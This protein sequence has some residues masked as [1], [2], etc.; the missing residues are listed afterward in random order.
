LDVGTSAVKG[1]VLDREGRVLARARRSY[2]LDLPAPGRVE[3][4]AERV[5]SAVAGV[6]G[7][8]GAGATAGGSPVRALAVSGSGDEVVAVDAAG[9][10]AGPVI[11]A[12][13]TRSAATAQALE[14][15]FGEARLYARTGLAAIGMAPLT[16]LLW[17]REYQPATAARIRRLLAW[18]EYVALRLGVEPRAEPTLAG[19]SLV[20]DLHTDAYAAD[21][22]E[23][24]D[25]DQ[26]TFPAIVPT[27]ARIGEVSRIMAGR[28]GLSGN[29]AVV[30]GGFDQAMAAFGA[31]ALD[32][33]TAHVGT[34]SWEALSAPL[35]G[36][37]I[38]EGLRIGGWSI[39]RTV[40][41]SATHAAMTSWV[42]GAVLHWLARLSSVDRWPTGRAPSLPRLLREAPDGP[43]R[44]LALT[45]LAG[46]SS[47]YP[48]FAGG[49]FVGLD[50][51]ASRGE[52]VA[53]ALESLTFHLRA[54]LDQ[55]ERAGIRV[56]TLRATGGGARSR[57]WLQ[58]KADVTGRVLE[59]P[60]IAET[61]ALAAAVLAGAAVDMWPST[62]DAIRTLTVIDLRAEPR[63]AYEGHYAERALLH[64]TLGEAL[65]R[66][67]PP[68]VPGQS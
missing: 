58:R 21:I 65:S 32:V 17:L 53:A 1:I 35:G 27:G 54:A 45:H 67:D 26:T 61:G 31:G 44:L 5:W 8:L 38:D 36:P 15:R 13:D 33:G 23:A 55:L 63:R 48:G 12:L 19:R 49:A 56:N 6:I 22:L 39:G 42:G 43:S 24:L 14:A 64:R 46:A 66:S 52:M 57:A 3:L 29:V 16:R 68:P 7:R 62:A 11:I 40:G 37:L 10:P 30:A 20:F 60:A 2:R 34:G 28:L 59:R 18:P 4:S 41:G 51:A 9:G 25:V 50:L 47:T